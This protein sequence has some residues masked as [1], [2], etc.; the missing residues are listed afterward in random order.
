MLTIAKLRSVSY[1][2][3]CTLI[4]AADGTRRKRRSWRCAL[5]MSSV[6]AHRCALL[7]L[8]FADLVSSWSAM[9]AMSIYFSP[10][11]GLAN[12][13]SLQSDTSHAKC[14]LLSHLSRSISEPQTSCFE[15]PLRPRRRGTALVLRSQAGI[16]LSSSDS[17]ESVR[18]R[19]GRPDD[20]PGLVELS[21]EAFQ[22]GGMIENLITTVELALQGTDLRTEVEGGLAR[23]MMMLPVEGGDEEEALQ[24]GSPSHFLLHPACSR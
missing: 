4:P 19:P 8:V 12:A 3:R 2:V 13:P 5:S 1:G 21:M 22:G 23:R 18:Y 7:V 15:L 9:Q 10:A 11:R 14:G 6:N 20:G 17:S 24:S 16:D